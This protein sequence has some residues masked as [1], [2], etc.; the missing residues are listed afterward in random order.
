MIQAAMY[1]AL[2]F[3]VAAALALMVAPVL[4]NRAIALTRQRIESSVPL[5]LNEIQAD[6]DQLRAEF[7]MSTRRLEMSIDKLREK[8]STQL[9]EI[10]RR[11]DEL[12]KLAEEHKEK[13]DRLAQA[14]ARG[15]DLETRLRRREER[16]EE[17]ERALGEAQTRLEERAAELERFEAALRNATEDVDA[18]RE[19]L[20]A[21]DDRLAQMAEDARAARAAVQRAEDDLAR[22]RDRVARR[23]ETIERLRA[24]LGER[25]E[26][27]DRVHAT[28]AAEAPDRA[29]FE[30]RIEELEA[31]NVR[32]EADLAQA[33]MRTGAVLE[34][35][36]DEN[37]AA[38][39]DSLKSENR[40]LRREVTYLQG[41]LDAAKVELAA[42]QLS[43][44]DEW[45]VERRENAIVRERINDLAAKV[46]AMTAEIEGPD[47]PIHRILAQAETGA[48]DVEA[49][50]AESSLS[51]ADRVRALQA[52][53]EK[54]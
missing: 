26:R 42:A 30:A 9:A 32:L 34:H 24:E 27:L 25:D 18:H 31:Q 54:G 28:M 23:E 44:R 10:S 5:T 37:V 40:D 4:W 46:V 20:S 29:A 12:T 21:R 8:A 53:A 52:L 7:A 36:S 19:E 22:E 48:T 14:E 43:G 50:G 11:R 38:A 13:L 6:K 41:E 45:E 39:L 1:M 16:L 35:A 3:L 47:S 51:L 15:D 33:L 17:T 2:G 49:G